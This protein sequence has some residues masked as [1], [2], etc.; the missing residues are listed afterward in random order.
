MTR[1]SGG[2]CVV[3]AVDLQSAM[4]QGQ[5]PFALRHPGNHE[6]FRAQCGSLVRAR[7]ARDQMID[8]A[9]GF[10]A[11]CEVLCCL[12]QYRRADVFVHGN[13]EAEEAAELPI[14]V[15]DAER[16]PASRPLFDS[17]GEGYADQLLAVYLS[18]PWFRRGIARG[19]PTE[20]AAARGE[21]SATVETQDSGGEQGQGP[22]PWVG[23]RGT[24]LFLHSPVL[25]H[26]PPPVLQ[27]EC[28]DEPQPEKDKAASMERERAKGSGAS[29]RVSPEEIIEL[30]ALSERFAAGDAEA[31]ARAEQLMQRVDARFSDEER[32]A[33]LE[34]IDAANEPRQGPESREPT[35]QM[36]LD[37]ATEEF[38]YSPQL[39]CTKTGR[40]HR[41][42]V[43]G[44][45]WHSQW[46][47]LLCLRA[48]TPL[49]DATR[50]SCQGSDI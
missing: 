19:P 39:V 36:M 29:A 17:L 31:E 42:I 15:N 47:T 16:T 9:A 24:G 50:V 14:G 5:F 27:E 30:M 45:F 1:L 2:A 33:S 38:R 6:G 4:A 35:R 20:A 3:D 11:C 41:M 25:P 21:A 7:L 46:L 44:G 12:L 26:L 18:L 8:L 40:L 48:L 10:P 32:R 37:A 22:W 28:P 34:R 23:R 43:G 13:R 49:I